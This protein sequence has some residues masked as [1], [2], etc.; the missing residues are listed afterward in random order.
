MQIKQKYQQKHD[1]TVGECV[2]ST[3][4]GFEFLIHSVWIHSKTKVKSI[5]LFFSVAIGFSVI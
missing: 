5:S 4:T 1:L 3:H 2:S